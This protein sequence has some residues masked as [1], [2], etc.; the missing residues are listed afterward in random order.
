M[1]FNSYLFLLLFL[2]LALLGYFALNRLGRRRAADLFLTGMSLWFYA[3]LA[4]V[5]LWVLC[6]SVVVNFAFSRWLARRFRRPAAHKLLLA[7]GILCNVAVLFYFKYFNFFWENLNTALGRSFTLQHIALPLGVSFFTF[8]QIAYLV[9]SYRGQTAGYS[10]GEYTLFVVFFPKLSQGPIALHGELIPQFRDPARRRPQAQNLARGLYVLALGLFKKV[11]LADTFAKAVDFGFADIPSLSSLE[12]LLV[13][14]S[15]AFQLYFDFSGYCDMAL[16]IAAMFNIDLPQN[17]DSPY[18]ALSI[19]DFWGRWHITLTRFLRTYLYFPLGGSRKGTARTYCNILVVFLVS[20]L[21]HGANW[22]F[23]VWGALHGLLNCLHRALRKPWARLHTVTQWLLTFLSVVVLWVFFRA[24]TL[25]D[26]VAF[27]KEWFRWSSFTIRPELYA[28]FD[29]QELLLAEQMLPGLR[30]L[31]A[32]MTG[33][34][35]W[36]FLFGAFFIVLNLPNNR[37]IRFRPALG[38]A[39]ATAGL[40][41][42]SIVSLADVSVF[43]YAN[44]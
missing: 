18:K 4:P 12:A 11:I 32:Q 2:P 27:L 14:L 21:W 38:T 24:D 1:L 41:F 35:L 31:A 43:L 13:A 33:C 8:Q 34:N 6:G 28:C 29:L 16:G 20:G 40:L 17:F 3:Y 36:L 22:T 7:A 25:G 26:A 42:W 44:F 15:Y 23:V 39:L 30:T 9:D 5:Y 19:P 10:F 37:E